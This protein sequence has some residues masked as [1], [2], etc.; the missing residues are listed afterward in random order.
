MFRFDA[1]LP[2]R[3]G[4]FSGYGEDMG[5]GSSIDLMPAA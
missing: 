3:G 1:L 2:V 5:H 4:N